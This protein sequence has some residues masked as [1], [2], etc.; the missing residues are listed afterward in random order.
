MAFENFMSDLAQ[1]RYY[2][3]LLATDGSEWSLE[4][5]ASYDSRKPGLVV[6]PISTGADMDLEAAKEM[7]GILNSSGLLNVD[8]SR[9]PRQLVLESVQFVATDTGV[10]NVTDYIN[11][12]AV[13]VDPRK[14]P[15]PRRREIHRRRDIDDA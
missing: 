7:A 5:A 11:A 1:N 15:L 12:P 14:P 10:R 2:C 8:A 6:T 13:Q 9:C 4:F 3:V